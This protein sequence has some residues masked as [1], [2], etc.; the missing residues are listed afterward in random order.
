MLRNA[1]PEIIQILELSDKDIKAA[2]LSILHAGRLNPLEMDGKVKVF[3][4]EIQAIK[5]N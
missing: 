5:K 1:N 3:S 4:Q 2:I